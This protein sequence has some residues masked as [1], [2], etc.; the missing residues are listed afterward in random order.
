MTTTIPE[1]TPLG[2]ML[3]A[4]DLGLSMKRQD[5]LLWSGRTLYSAP[6]CAPSWHTN[7]WQLMYLLAAR[8]LIVYSETLARTI[9]FAEDEQAKDALIVA[10]AEESSIYTLAEIAAL[11]K[12]NAQSVISGKELCLLDE[13]KKVFNGRFR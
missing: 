3:K 1:N 8:F 7:K 10:G 6:P 11:S 12:A 2:V 9:F 4:L 13:A 5:D